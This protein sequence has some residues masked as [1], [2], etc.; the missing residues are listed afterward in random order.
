MVMWPAFQNNIHYTLSSYKNNTC[1]LFRKY[2]K[3]QRTKLNLIFDSWLSYVEVNI[4]SKLS[5]W[6]AISLFWQSIFSQ[7][8]HVIPSR[9]VIMH[10]SEYRC[11]GRVSNFWPWNYVGFV[12]TINRHLGVTKTVCFFFKLLNKS[13]IMIDFW[14]PKGTMLGA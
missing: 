14:Y 1:W 7:N 2:R 8:F 10:S 9:C 3:V 13:V 11:R 6:D 5:P 4:V 12:R